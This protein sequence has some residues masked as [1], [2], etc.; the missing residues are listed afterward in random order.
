MMIFGVTFSEQYSLHLYFDSE[1]FSEDEPQLTDTDRSSTIST[2]N[3]VKRRMRNTLAQLDG[4]RKL[5]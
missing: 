3:P 2:T 5:T 4:M 1:F